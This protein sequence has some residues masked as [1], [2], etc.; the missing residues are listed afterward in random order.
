MFGLPKIFYKRM[1]A[2]LKGWHKGGKVISGVY[3][4][5]LYHVD[6][7]KIPDPSDFVGGGRKDTE[8]YYSYCMIY[9]GDVPEKPYI[10]I[11]LPFLTLDNLKLDYPKEPWNTQEE[12]T[13]VLKQSRN[14][15]EVISMARSKIGADQNRLEHAL[16]YAANAEE[17]ITD[18]NSR[19]KDTDMSEEVTEQAK[20][21]VLANAQ[22][23]ML[24]QLAKQPERVVSLLK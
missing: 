12:I 6:A 15:A 8:A 4:N 22:E 24:T 21:T 2:I 13:T 23:A 10:P 11:H 16:A 19:I 9:A 5:F 1:F 3:T 14:A 18:A 17:Q 7:E 20:L